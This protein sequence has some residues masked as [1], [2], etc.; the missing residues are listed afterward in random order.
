MFFHIF[1]GFRS[2]LCG[3]FL[4]I[5]FQEFSEPAKMWDYSLLN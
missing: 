2:A 4:L 1:Y 3:M 5:G